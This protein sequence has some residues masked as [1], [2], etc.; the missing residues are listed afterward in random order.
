MQNYT[1]IHKIDKHNFTQVYTKWTNKTLHEDTHS[2]G[3]L[4]FSQYTLGNLFD[5]SICIITATQWGVSLTTCAVTAMDD[6]QLR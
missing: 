4:L 3:F 6:D 5:V 1:E 2:Y